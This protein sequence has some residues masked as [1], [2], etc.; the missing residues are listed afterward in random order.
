MKTLE[1]L[2]AIAEPLLRKS[3]FVIINN[4]LCIELAPDLFPNTKKRIYSANLR[5]DRTYFNS[6]RSFLGQG[7]TN[8]R[9]LCQMIL[10][11]RDLP[12]YPTKVFAK[13]HGDWFKDHLDSFSYDDENSIKCVLC[14]RDYVGL[15]WWSD[16]KTGIIGPCCLYGQCQEKK[17]A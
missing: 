16:P 7:S 13:W 5:N 8:E 15:D 10:W 12:R 2:N 9:T 4:R 14:K 11:Y 17:H 1:Q 6:R 3:K